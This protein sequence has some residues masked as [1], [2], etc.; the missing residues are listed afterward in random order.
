MKN[1]SERKNG[2]FRYR[3]LFLVA[4]FLGVAHW[5]Y[6][7]W[8]NPWR[9]PRYGLL[10]KKVVR[11]EWDRDHGFTKF[12]VKAYPGDWFVERLLRGLL[13]VQLRPRVAVYLKPSNGKYLFTGWRALVNKF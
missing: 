8:D 7:T 13:S 2:P 11:F 5:I 10:T 9:V 4:L 12:D 6:L 3:N 1:S